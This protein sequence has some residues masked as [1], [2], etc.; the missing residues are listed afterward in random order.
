MQYFKLG[1]RANYFYDMASR[2]SI[3][4]GRIIALPSM[5]TSSYFKSALKSGHIVRVSEAE[6]LKRFPIPKVEEEP[7]PPVEEPKTEEVSYT[8]E[9]LEDMTMAQILKAY[10]YFDEED[11]GKAKSKRSKKSLIKFV[12]ETA[13]DYA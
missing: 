8:K 12:L 5:P 10:S 4:R 9:D 7:T 6:Y 13:E 3:V 2:I 1:P 11:M